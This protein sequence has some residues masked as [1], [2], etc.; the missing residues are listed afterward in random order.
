M[1][2]R[3]ANYNMDQALSEIG[4]MKNIIDTKVETQVVLQLMVEKGI[5]TREE[6]ANMRAKVKSQPY[7][8]AAYDYLD[9]AKKKAEYYKSNPQDH[10]RDVL[11]AKMNG[12]IR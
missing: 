10:L 6:V 1:L 5:V 7:Y 8:K 2:S 9:G 12:D 4:N 11:N 3:D